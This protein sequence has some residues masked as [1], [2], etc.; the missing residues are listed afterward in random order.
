MAYRFSDVVLFHIAQNCFI[1]WHPWWEILFCRRMEEKRE[2]VAKY[3]SGRV[4]IRWKSCSRIQL[5]G[6]HV[7]SG[8]VFVYM[9]QHVHFPVLHIFT[10]LSQSLPKIYHGTFH[11]SHCNSARLFT[12]ELWNAINVLGLILHWL[13]S[14]LV[15]MFSFL[16]MQL[17]RSKIRIFHMCEPHRNTDQTETTVSSNYSI[18]IP[19]RCCLGRFPDQR[20][21]WECCASRIS[22]DLAETILLEEGDDVVLVWWHLRDPSLP[23]SDNCAP[24]F[25]GSAWIWA[26]RTLQNQCQKPRGGLSQC[27]QKLHVSIL[28][29]L[30]K[31]GHNICIIILKNK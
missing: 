17:F 14:N 23:N 1:W 3:G 7:L 25:C 16:E 22:W 11:K 4:K 24:I 21:S 28:V 2:C 19:R 6:N 27:Q 26:K 30:L 15:P 31:A 18:E 29:F 5:V 8:G 12:C 10:F 13:W 20:D 9:R